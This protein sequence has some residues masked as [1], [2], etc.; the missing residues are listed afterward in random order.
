[1]DVTRL[2]M[3]CLTAPR[4]AFSGRPSRGNVDGVRSRTRA[5]VG[6]AV[7]AL[8][9]CGLLVLAWEF[10]FT[11]ALSGGSYPGPYWTRVAPFAAAGVLCAVASKIAHRAG[12]HARLHQ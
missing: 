4:S 2:G 12:G 9:G 11:W 7:L 1:V 10:S 6:A 8:V 3:P 5:L